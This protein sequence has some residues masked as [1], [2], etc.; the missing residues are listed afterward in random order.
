M[1]DRHIFYYH[2]WLCWFE[3]FTLTYYMLYVMLLKL[4]KITCSMM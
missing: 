2:H 1:R 4:M 3:C